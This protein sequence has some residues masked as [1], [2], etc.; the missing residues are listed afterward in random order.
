[1]SIPVEGD[2]HKTI[3]FTT[4][5]V[6]TGKKVNLNSISKLLNEVFLKPINKNHMTK[7]I[8]HVYFDIIA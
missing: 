6:V 7:T 5:F 2:M 1:M 8:I 3:F 4:F